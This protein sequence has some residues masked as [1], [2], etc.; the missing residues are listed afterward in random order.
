LEINFRLLKTVR[1]FSK[2]G[3]IGMIMA[4]CKHMQGYRIQRPMVPAA[5]VFS[6][7]PCTP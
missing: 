7:D 4:G 2:D 6:I 1:R 5:L 3:K